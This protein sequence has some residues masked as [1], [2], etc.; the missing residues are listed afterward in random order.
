ME[1]CANK[2]NE[3]AWKVITRLA[4]FRYT[5]EPVDTVADL[6]NKYPVGNDDGV[7]CFVKNENTFYRFYVRERIWTPIG[8][9]T[10]F[11][12]WVQ[13]PGNEGKTEGDFLTWLKAEALEAADTANAAAENANQAAQTANAAAEDALDI[14]NTAAE[15][16]NTAAEAANTAAT[17]ANTASESANTAAQYAREQGDYAAEQDVVQFG[18]R[19]DKVEEDKIDGG[20]S[21][22]GLLYLTSGGTVVGDPIPVGSGGGGSG[23]GGGG[24]TL[25]LQNRGSASMGVPA[26]QPAW[27]RYTFTSTDSETGTPTGYGTVAYFVNNARVY[28]KSIP[29]GDVDFDIA[30]YLAD[31]KNQVLIQVTDSYGTI[32]ALNIR[33]EIIS[34]RLMSTFDDSLVY[35]SPIRFPYTPVGTGEKTIH[36]ILDD[37]E[38]ES[39]TTT[40]TNRQLYYDLP[41]L[42]HGSHSFEVYA[43]MESEGVIITSNILRFSIIYVL[44]DSTDVIISS[45]FTLT[46]ASQY[47]NLA[48]PFSIYNPAA[49][50]AQVQLKANGETVSTLTVDR[51]PQVWAYRIPGYGALNLAIVCGNVT[52][53]FNLSVSKSP[54]NSEAETENLELFL[55]SD[56][57]SNHETNPGVWED[58]NIEAVF[59]GFNYKTNGWVADDDGVTTLRISQGAKVE[60]P[61]FPFFSDFKPSGKTIEMEFRVRNV[62]NF[63]STIISCFS[64]GRGFK[65]TANDILFQSELSSVTAKF[66]E[67][68]KIRISFVV[69]SRLKNRI[70]YTYINGI[71]SGS[72]RYAINDNFE[73]APPV[74]ITLGS[75]DC[76]LDVYNLRSY[77]MDLNAYQILNNYIADTALVS[78]KLELY[79]NNQVYDSTGEI[80][81]SLLSN[82]LPCMTIIG[83]LPTFKG[84]KKTVSMTFE[85][86]QSP[87]R[88]FTADNVQIDV[89]G[90][91]SQYY[92]RKNFKH[93]FKSGLTL[94]QTG[95]QVDKYAL[96]E[97]SIPVDTFCEKADFAESSGTHNTGMSK[98]IDKVLRSMNYL[99]PPQVGNDNVRSTV[100][101]YPI[102]IFHKSNAHSPALF[103]GKYNFNNDK[104]TQETF[105]FD[106]ADECCY[107][108]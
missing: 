86:R 12:V 42:G 32:R 35:N 65:I 9:Y 100:D 31:G 95:E 37:E 14:A 103:I 78:R 73:Q 69:E 62:E 81:Y 55:T 20:Y 106:G 50:T 74:G 61:F 53:E 2:I 92:P 43:T 87:E 25:R 8:G 27:L 52:K 67:D 99:T 84:D 89:Q 30:N 59:T 34:L 75:S 101:G 10:S 51:L 33:V 26:G 85:N 16:A 108:K 58:N 3:D 46:E 24:S 80:V 68:E 40:A 45:S 107:P 44:S 49:S 47:D 64:F 97:D 70:I 41:V 96:K 19:L 15:N 23:G 104:S 82:Q 77:G 22:E 17:A 28:T 102:A 57:R 66:K 91:S 7:F 88:S 6:Y 36:F 71:A 56:G 1:D 38:L 63:T 83:E 48:I 4:A 72:I 60:I 5:K 94:T 90:T 13:Q 29:Q 98:Y 11:E 21:E 39:V 79:D 105:G 54:I 18:H 93:K 76:T